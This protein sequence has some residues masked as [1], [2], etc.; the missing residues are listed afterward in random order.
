M[1]FK[2]ARI[3]LVGATGTVGAEV[4]NELEQLEFPANQLRVFASPSSRGMRVGYGKRDLVIEAL[5][6][7]VLGTLDLVIGVT[8]ADAAREW[9]P[10]ALDSGCIVVDVSEAYRTDP[11]VPLLIAGVNDHLM[12]LH[13]R[14]RL[15]ACPGSLATQLCVSLKP[16]ASHADVVRVVVATYQ[17]ASD[18]GRAGMDALSNQVLRLYRQSHLSEERH[19]EEEEDAPMFSSQLAFNGIPQ[20]GMFLD[21]GQTSSEQALM[22]ESRRVLE[23]PLLPMAVTCARMP[24]F[25]CHALAVHVEFK[26]ELSI[27]EA[28]KLFMAT[29]GI[30][31]EDRPLE[32]CFPTPFAHAGHDLVYIGRLR[33]D[34]SVPHGLS[35]W[36][37]SDNLRQGSAINVVRVVERVISRR[38][39][40]ATLH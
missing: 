38:P 4:L 1:S 7:E 28:R 39:T 6:P 15:I 9:I 31:L 21:E 32:G 25:A 35:Y 8:P 3:G 26:T 36:S 18:S 10:T 16:I 22:D 30:E 33:A 13:T 19:G 27:Y 12:G 20:V 34:S 5:S 2:E 40:G 23:A 11:N 24:W 37:V 29:D 17:S 14:G